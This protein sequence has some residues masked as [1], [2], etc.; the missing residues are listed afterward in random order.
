MTKAHFHVVFIKDWCLYSSSGKQCLD[1]RITS[2]RT[3]STTIGWKSSPAKIFHRNSSGERRNSS[4]AE[5]TT[6][7]RNREAERKSLST[8]K[9]TSSTQRPQTCTEAAKKYYNY[10]T[11]E[12]DEEREHRL[13]MLQKRRGDQA[14]LKVNFTVRK[15]I[16]FDATIVNNSHMIYTMHMKNIFLMHR[17]EA[18]SLYT[19]S[20]RFYSKL[21]FTMNR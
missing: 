2:N 15:V 6:T 13:P 14:T 16:F 5:K 19:I 20:I 21:Y 7:T 18:I 11:N 10:T 3:A 17:G 1:R 9:A 8:A 4:R 12:T